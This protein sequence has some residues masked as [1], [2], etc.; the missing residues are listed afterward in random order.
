MVFKNN[1]KSRNAANYHKNKL[2]NKL[3]KTWSKT[4]NPD[5]LS[6]RQSNI[7]NKLS[8]NFT[9]F[10]NDKERKRTLFQMIQHTLPLN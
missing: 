9:T 6:K 1:Q 5:T 3:F 4:F 10:K 8:H 7:W 2:A